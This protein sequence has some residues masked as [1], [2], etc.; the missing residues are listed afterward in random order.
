MLMVDV[1]RKGGSTKSKRLTV[2]DCTRGGIV[3]QNVRFYSQ[4]RGGRVKEKN[5]STVVCAREGAW[6]KNWKIVGSI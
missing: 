4:R 3:N 5:V 6:V 2:V 1:C